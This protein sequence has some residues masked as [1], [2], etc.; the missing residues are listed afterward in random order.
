MT[1]KFKLPDFIETQRASFLTF[2]EK[3]IAEEIQSISPIQDQTGS[4]Q[5]VFY[6]DLVK[7]KRPKPLPKEAIKKSKTYSASV[8][9]PAQLLF[10]HPTKKMKSKSL[11]ENVFLGEIPFMTERGTF[12]INGSPRVVVNQ[13]VR[14]PG[15][16][17]SMQFDKKNKRTFIGSIISNRGSWLRIETDKKGLVFVRIDKVRKIPIFVFL[18]EY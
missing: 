3:G 5:L 2:L 12:I 11:I 15:I 6:P 4:I 10:T 9:V 8:Y 16:Y 13:I 14:I 18:F 7:F 17:Y 1:Q